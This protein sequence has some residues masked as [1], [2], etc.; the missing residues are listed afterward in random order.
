MDDL[1]C[2][3]SREGGCIGPVRWR[4]SLTGTGLR[5]AR[6]RG[7]YRAKTEKA[8]RAQTPPP[9]FDPAYAGERWDEPEG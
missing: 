7:H 9:G 5:V 1:Q 6:C 4:E 3:D 8:Q 2:R